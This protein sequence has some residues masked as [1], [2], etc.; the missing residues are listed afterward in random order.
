MEAEREVK[1][2]AQISEL[3]NRKQE[4]R[5]RLASKMDIWSLR[6]S[7]DIFKKMSCRFWGMEYS[8]W[9]LAIQVW[10]SM[11]SHWSTKTYTKQKHWALRNSTILILKRGLGHFKFDLIS[12]LNWY[13]HVKSIRTVQICC[14][15]LAKSIYKIIYL[16]PTYTYTHLHIPCQSLLNCLDAIILPIQIELIILDFITSGYLLKYRLKRYTA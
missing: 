15:A 11:H 7:R 3:S 9:K 8:I 6:S 10:L 4:K 1:N 12:V 14:K 16:T 2:M 13:F 5:R